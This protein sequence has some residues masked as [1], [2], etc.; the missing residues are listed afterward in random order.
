[1]INNEL[2]RRYYVLKN[3]L[4][5]VSQIFCLDISA[6]FFFHTLRKYVM[7]ERMEDGRRRTREKT[8]KRQKI[9]I[10]EKRCTIY[11]W[12]APQKKNLLPIVVSLSRRN[13]RH[14]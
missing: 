14:R 2:V 5:F 9:K 7:D 10:K 12:S 8:E 6:S 4:D 13:E 1:M 3:N 11:T